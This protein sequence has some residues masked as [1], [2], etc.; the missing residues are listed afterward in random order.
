VSHTGVSFAPF[1]LSLHERV[2]SVWYRLDI[3]IDFVRSSRRTV[4]IA[5]A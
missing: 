1:W 2:N 3:V 5:I 4:L